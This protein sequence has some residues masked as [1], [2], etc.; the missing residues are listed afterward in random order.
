[1]Q[2]KEA[3]DAVHKTEIDTI[4]LVNIGIIR[5]MGQYVKMEKYFKSCPGESSPIAFV[6]RPVSQHPVTKIVVGGKL[7]ERKNLRPGLTQWSWLKTKNTTLIEDI[8]DH[9]H[10]GREAGVDIR[11]AASDGR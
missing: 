2:E 1:M 4:S 7:L 11:N 6:V 10:E 8:R 9:V 5:W 3:F